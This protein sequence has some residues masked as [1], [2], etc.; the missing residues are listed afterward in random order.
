MGE[1]N[2]TPQHEP[3][4]L[5]RAANPSDLAIVRRLF[6]SRAQTLINTLLGFDG[7]FNFYY[8]YKESIPLDA[9]QEET[10]AHALKIC[11]AGVDLHEIYERVTIR[12]GKSFLPH[13]AWGKVVRDIIRVKD[14]WAFCLSALELHN[15]LVKRVAESGGARRVVVGNAGLARKPLRG[16]AGPS[17]LVE[18]KGYPTT[19]SI[20]CL[21]KMLAAKALRT[22][23]G[24]EGMRLGGI[25][26]RR[27]ERV[28]GA[29]GTGRS[30]ALSTGIKIEK[31]GADYEPEHDTCL[32]AFV[33]LLAELVMG[34]G[35]EGHEGGI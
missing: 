30:K 19:A 23:Y 1:G 35:E 3:T 21:Q 24:L 32:Q 26:S 25:E 34:D 9:S 22:G 4:A 13:A 20:S 7:Y 11:R 15:A 29:T 18:R 27:R 8:P 31:L 14:V 5:E 12:N 33:R 2:E 10:E 28:F 6:G 17:Q 16:K